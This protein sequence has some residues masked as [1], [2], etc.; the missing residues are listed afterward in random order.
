MAK[1]TTR[2]LEVTATLVDGRINSH[3][4]IIMLDSILYHAWFLKNAPEVFEGG[5]IPS[6]DELRNTPTKNLPNGFVRRGDNLFM[7]VGLPITKREDGIY[8][9]SMGVYK[10]VSENIEYWNKR[11]DFFSA[12]K[13]EH[14]DQEKGVLSDSMG[15]YRAYRTPN[16]IR[17]VKDRVITFYC[18]GTGDKVF[19]LLST[20]PAVGKKP[21]VGWGIVEKWEVKEI[22]EDYSFMHPIHGLMRP[23]PVDNIQLEG[24]SIMDYAIK[25][26]YYKIVNRRRC[27]I[28]NVEDMYG[29][30]L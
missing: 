4:G 19:D 18:H 23:I 1:K 21:S 9:A 5:G 10:Q 16:L 3:D 13:M 26:P 25:P 11:P 29:R 20:I 24:Y 30:G 22:E 15:A 12:D 6:L 17:T 27:Y 2:P 7:C 28:P 8:H 14:L